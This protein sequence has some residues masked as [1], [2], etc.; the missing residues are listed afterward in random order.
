M[1]DKELFEKILKCTEYINSASRN[2]TGNY[3]VVGSGYQKIMEHH[4]KMVDREEKLRR[5][6]G[7]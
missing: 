1:E 4:K 7:K 5:I 3:I 6:L 2:Y